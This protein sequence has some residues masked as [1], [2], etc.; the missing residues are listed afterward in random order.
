MAERIINHLQRRISRRE[1]LRNTGIAVV[2]ITGGVIGKKLGA[3]DNITRAL[4]NG[5]TNTIIFDLAG[6]KHS[7]IMGLGTMAGNLLGHEI[8]ERT[9]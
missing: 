3:P 7:V 5:G 6:F 8:V 4:T 1:F 9:K 2:E